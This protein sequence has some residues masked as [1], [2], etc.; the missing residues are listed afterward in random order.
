MTQLHDKEARSDTVTCLRM[1]AQQ[2][3]DTQRLW[4]KVLAFTIVMIGLE[5]VGLTAV[6]VLL[7]TLPLERVGCA[8]ALALVL[9]ATPW[10]VVRHR[11]FRVARGLESMLI[12][13]GEAEGFHWIHQSEMRGASLDRLQLLKAAALELNR[14]LAADPGLPNQAMQ[15]ARLEE[16][17]APKPR[18]TAWAFGALLHYLVDMLFKRRESQDNK[19]T[20]RKTGSN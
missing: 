14:G 9:Y 15:K 19:E 20:P 13:M 17:S 8:A 12:A 3:L 7:P 18:E 1:A 10:Y 16:Q 11:L 2:F 5:I 4:D 6:L